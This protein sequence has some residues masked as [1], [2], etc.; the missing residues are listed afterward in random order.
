M[1]SCPKSDRR[2]N[3]QSKPPDKVCRKTHRLETFGVLPSEAHK[4]EGYDKDEDEAGAATEEEALAIEA[5]RA[6][7]K[8][9]SDEDFGFAGL[10]P[11]HAEAP[12]PLRDRHMVETVERSFEMLSEEERFKV[13]KRE[14]PE[15][16]AMMEE[17]KRY[18]AEAK[19]ASAP[20]H[21]LVHHRRRSS[22]DRQLLSFLETK[23]HLMLAYCLHVA[24]YLLLKIEGRKVSGHPVVDRLVE[25]R[26]YLEK[27][28]PLEAKLQ[29]SLNRLMLPTTKP[30]AANVKTLRPVQQEPDGIYQPIRNAVTSEAKMRRKLRQITKDADEV[31]KQEAETMTRVQRKKVDMKPFEHLEP[32]FQGYT[33]QEDQYF[34]KMVGEVDDDDDAAEGLTLI[35]KIRRRNSNVPQKMEE[36]REPV[37]SDGGS[38]EEDLLGDDE[39]GDLAVQY[40]DLVGEQRER[41]ER[42]RQAVETKA[43]Q[44]DPKEVKRRKIDQRIESHRGL[45]KARPKDRK[46]PKT[47][48][49]FKYEK[50]MRIHKTQTKTV[51][52]EPESGFQGVRNLKPHV[53]HST[54]L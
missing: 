33:E 8:R 27:L 21:E 43:P 17:V 38:D 50:A 20:L 52:P 42:N 28:W 53:T 19:E 44:R 35:E 9:M 10:R 41:E 39:D 13:L 5:V 26:V 47:S 31:E 12:S 6:M 54:K 15:L 32:S 48:K 11:T 34:S 7:K 23:V 16:I 1:H 40:D 3:T 30:A 22:V 24:F 37:S 25:L 46:T 14:S 29:Y 36:V 18:L 51:Q 49:R 2:K 4:A 45:T